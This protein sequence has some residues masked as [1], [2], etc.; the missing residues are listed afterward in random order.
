[1]PK[2]VSLKDGSDTS[3][4]KHEESSDVGSAVKVDHSDASHVNFASPSTATIVDTRRISI[5]KSHISLAANKTE[6]RLNTAAG[7]V[8]GEQADSYQIGDL[9]FVKHLGW[10]WPA[11]IEDPSNV[12]DIVTRFQYAAFLYGIH[13]RKVVKLKDV[14]LYEENKHNFSSKT[15]H[16][17]L[18]IALYEVENDPDVNI[19]I[20]PQH[21]KQSIRY[22]RRSRSHAQLARYL[23]NHHLCLEETGS[24]ATSITEISTSEGESQ[25]NSMSLISHDSGLGYFTIFSSFIFMLYL[26]WWLVLMPF[27]EPSYLQVL[28]EYFPIV[29]QSIFYPIAAGTTLVS[30]IIV[31]VQTQVGR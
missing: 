27:L 9:V 21:K 4:T 18:N 15:D 16:H 22:L 10:P 14:F 28:E 1:M 30:S 19:Q 12:E 31:Y 23:E 17:I 7:V 5:L 8:Q 20:V 25:F 2:S 11:C 13:E 6:K 26:T 3:A 24:E 29:S